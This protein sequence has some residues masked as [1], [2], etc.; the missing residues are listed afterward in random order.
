MDLIDGTEVKLTSQ[1]T[2]PIEINAP[3]SA[4]FAAEHATLIEGAA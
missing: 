4:Y 2:L 1:A 3:V